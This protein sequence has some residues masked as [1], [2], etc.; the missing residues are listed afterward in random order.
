MEEVVE[1]VIGKN[2]K[3][4]DVSNRSILDAPKVKIQNLYRA[5]RNNLRQ[6]QRTAAKK[7][8]DKLFGD[9]SE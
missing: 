3:L 7:K 1:R 8:L 5:D 4:K 2:E 9:V 6:S